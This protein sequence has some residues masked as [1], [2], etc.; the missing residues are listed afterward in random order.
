MAL[1]H[2]LGISIALGGDIDGNKIVAHG[3][4]YSFSSSQSGQRPSRGSQFLLRL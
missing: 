4:G 3:S 2:H 1:E